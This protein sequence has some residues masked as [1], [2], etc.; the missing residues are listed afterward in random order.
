MAVT[1]TISGT[2]VTFPTSGTSPDWAPA[3]TQ[4]AQLV[5]QAL[6]GVAGSFD[7][8]PQSQTIDAYNPGVNIDI[9]SLTFPVSDVRAAFIPYAVFRSTNSTTVTEGGELFIVYNPTNPNGNKWSLAQRIS[10]GD[11][12]ISFAITDSGQVSF[13]TEVLS[14]SNHVGTLS[15]SGRAIL[16]E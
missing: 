4:F 9:G 11:A 10:G 7:V 5:E 12:S 15:F 8:P 3:L 6:A 16:Q 1:I 2:P 13:T 14:G